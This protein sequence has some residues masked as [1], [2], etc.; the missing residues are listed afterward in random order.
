[1]KYKS[2][3]VR[4]NNSNEPESNIAADI[5]AAWLL[6][7]ASDGVKRRQW[8]ED[9]FKVQRERCAYCN[10]AMIIDNTTEYSDRRAT[11]D[12]VVARSRGGEDIFENVVASCAAC[13]TAKSDLTREQFLVH[14]VRLLRL[15]Q[16]NTPPDRLAADPK[17]PF[18][19]N[20]AM[21]RG[22]GLR[23]RGQERNDVEE[24][25][26]SESWV[27][28][29]AGKSVDRRGRAITIKLSGPVEAYYRDV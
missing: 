29:P 14:P 7:T 20:E 18:Y 9:L 1:M 11:I 16:S 8:L 10:V 15:S 21:T 28:V 26:I 23:F 3:N 24:Y 5:E 27:K 13:N 25:C 19:N 4:S 12:H 22:V 6:H 2:I 17:S